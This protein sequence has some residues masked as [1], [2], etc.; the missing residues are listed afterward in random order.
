MSTLAPSLAP[1]TTVAVLGAGRLGGVLARAL[2]AADI[3]VYGPIRREERIPDVDIAL[4]CV[5]DSAIA[6][7]ALAA[8]PHAGLIGHVSGATPL[9]DVDFSLHPLQTF[10]GAEAPDVFRGVGCAVDGRTDE[11]LAA[12]SALTEM[13]GAR[14]FR[15]EDSG[16]AGY[17]ASASL[18]S[19]LVLA[20]LDAAE[21]VANASGIPASD[22]RMLLA[23]LVRRSIE[24]WADA[25]AAGALT[26]PIARGD[27]ATVDR[28][29]A[30]IAETQPELLALF[31]ELCDRTRV[32]AASRDAV[33][34]REEEHRA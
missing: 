10:T 9:D 7:A 20:V 3:E 17:H 4:L 28:Q 24:N 2:R 22:A 25:G 14:P 1:A 8:R 31:D 32:I 15:V 11:A 23:P 21:Q 16:R 12:A 29:R 5:P 6:D 18:A 26:G 30:A 19:N 27:E 34:V 33:A 13:L